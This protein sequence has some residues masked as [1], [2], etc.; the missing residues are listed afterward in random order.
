MSYVLTIV[1]FLLLIPMIIIGGI[2]YA[3]IRRLYPILLLLSVYSYISTVAYVIDSFHF[4]RTATLSILV[5][6]AILL[7]GFGLIIARMQKR[8]K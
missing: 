3:T 4:G 8:K 7:T 6:S 5:F 1:F 2:L